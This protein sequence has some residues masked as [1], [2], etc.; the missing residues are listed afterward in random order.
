MLRRV[1]K[2]QKTELSF[3]KKSI[4]EAIYSIRKSSKR[5]DIH[6][7]FKALVKGNTRNIDIHLVEKEVIEI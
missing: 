4:I 6:N 5:P 7:I 2:K 1:L 3:S